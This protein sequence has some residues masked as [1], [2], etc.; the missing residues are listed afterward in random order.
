MPESVVFFAETAPP[1]L[2]APRVPQRTYLERMKK[3]ARRRQILL[4]EVWD[5]TTGTIS[6]KLS[7]ETPITVDEFLAFAAYFHVDPAELLTGHSAPHGINLPHM[8]PPNTL[9]GT[10][11]G[12]LDRES[13]V[14]MPERLVNTWKLLDAVASKYRAQCDEICDAVDELLMQIAHDKGAITPKARAH[15]GGTR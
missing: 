11:A 7:G 1:P 14:A 9:A 15:S 8:K 4:V 3:C 10:P 12:P 13:E 5:A 2:Y 6:R